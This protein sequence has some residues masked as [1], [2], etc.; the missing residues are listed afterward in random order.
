MR[1]K[2]IYGLQYHP[3]VSHTLFGRCVFNNFLKIC[4]VKREY[5]VKNFI[6]EKIAELKDKLGD[7][8][9]IMAVSGGV[10]STV[11]ATLLHKAIGTKLHCVF[12]NNGFL[13]KGEDEDVPRYLREYGLNIC[14]L[15]ESNL[16]FETL[17]GINDPEEKRKGI[18]TIFIKLFEQYARNITVDKD[19]KW[20]GQGTIYPDVIESVP[21]FGL[22]KSHHN[23]GGLP[24]DMEMDLVEPLRELFK[25]EVREVGVAL[26]VPDFMI[27]RHPFPGPG[28][29]IRIMGDLTREKTKILQEAD[30]I[31]MQKLKDEDLYDKIWQAGVVLLST[32][33]VGVMGDKRTYEYVAALRAVNSENGMTAEPYDFH[34]RFLREISTEIINKVEGINRVVYDVSSKPP[35]TI[36]WE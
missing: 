26:E 19:I 12:I 25:D 16:F 8:E 7:D 32:K 20:L 21:G 11:A 30:A 10:D 1:E 33:S 31:F 17:E 3:E 29:A 22:I 4:R 14:S 5:T 6:K 23:V 34:G 24:D 28:L 13:R 35:A 15:D 27:K 2:N 36:E 18:G 9:V